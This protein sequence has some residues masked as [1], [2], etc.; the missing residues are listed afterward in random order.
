MGSEVEELKKE[1]ES[2]PEAASLE[3]GQQEQAVAEEQVPEEQPPEQ[4]PVPQPP[5]PQPVPQAPSELDRWIEDFRKRLEIVKEVASVAREI[6]SLPPE[7]QSAVLSILKTAMPQQQVQ[8]VEKPVVIEK[9]VEKVVEK[10]VPVVSSELQKEVREIRAVVE[11]IEKRLTYYD[12]VL[13][14]YDQIIAR[15]T[16][17]GASVS[18]IVSEITRLRQELD[19]VRRE[20]DELLKRIAEQYQILPKA[21]ITTPDGKVI[22]EYDFHPKLKAYEK[23][24]DFAVQQLGPA[25]IAEIRATR[26]DISS[27][28]TR[29]VSLVEAIVTPELRRRAPRIVEEIEDRLKRLV[30]RI[31]PEER[32]KTLAELEQKVSQLMQATQAT[33]GEQK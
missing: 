19:E 1:I 6:A 13:K 11:G 32:E 33:G 7:A 14:R 20:R 16:E 4:Q 27:H 9:P 23:Q 25:I 5:A 3:P 30:G 18:N 31:A 10:P 21:R 28:L 12:E 2:L 22:E 26:A 17:V 29:L 15:L 24:V 8:V